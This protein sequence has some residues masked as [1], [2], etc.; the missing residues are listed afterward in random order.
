VDEVSLSLGE[1]E[2][3]ALVGPNGAGKST[4][5]NLVSGHHVPDRGRVSLAGRE[6]TRLPPSHPW[7]R[8][9]VRSYQDAG[10]FPRLSAIENLMVPAVAR[11]IPRR[12]AARRARAVLEVLGLLPVGWE[13]ADRLSGGQRKLVDFGRSLMVDARVALLD[14]PT[15]G[16]N[17]ALSERMA[18]LVRERQQVG[19]AFLIV[20][21]DLPWAFSLCS[22]VIVL[23][24]GRVLAEGSPEEIKN[25]ARVR[26]AYLA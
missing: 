19:V 23:A 7:R 25:D 13:R 21:H 11:G 4:F 5:I 10:I 22:R 15:A 14:E 16:V 12:K 18:T 9:V 17:P 20:S 3:V 1:G 26:E 2:L 24:F 8:A 6:V